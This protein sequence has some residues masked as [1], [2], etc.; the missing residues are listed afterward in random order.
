[1]GTHCHFIADGGITGSHD[2]RSFGWRVHER[3]FPGKW[4]DSACQFDAKRFWQAVCKAVIITFHDRIIHFIDNRNSNGNSH[5]QYACW[6]IGDNYSTTGS[7]RDRHAYPTVYYHASISKSNRNWVPSNGEASTWFTR[8]F[9]TGRN[10]RFNAFK[11][12]LAFCFIVYDLDCTWGLV[13]LFTTDSRLNPD[14]PKV[15]NRVR[16]IY[17]RTLLKWS[18]LGSSRFPMVRTSP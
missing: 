5:Y 4:Y 17:R 12:S 18:S 10:L 6:P 3:L 2:S 7:D 11:A 8:P 16:L 15:R 9:K 14:P 13:Y 1:V